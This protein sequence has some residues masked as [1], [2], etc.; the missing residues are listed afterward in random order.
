[1]PA[2]GIIS[3]TGERSWWRAALAICIVFAVLGVQIASATHAHDDC[4]DHR[5]CC[6]VCHAGHTPVL[7]TVAESGVAPPGLTD[8]DV[9]R[10]ESP[11]LRCHLPASHFSRAPPA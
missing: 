10:E 5:H 9:Q 11:V 2:T 8:W 7:Q 3:L 4:G 6:P 1:M